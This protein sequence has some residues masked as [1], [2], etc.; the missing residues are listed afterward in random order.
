MNTKQ[1]FL[2]GAPTKLKTYWVCSE[3]GRRAHLTWDESHTIKVIV[4][5]AALSNISVAVRG[6][7]DQKNIVHLSKAEN[8]DGS[9]VAT[10]PDEWTR[11]CPVNGLKISL[12][13]L[14]SHPHPRYEQSVV[15]TFPTSQETTS[16]FPHLQ[17]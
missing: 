16:I 4:Q 1:P 3:S 7:L 15:E 9:A 14:A 5:S 10:R 13:C 17:G 11:F 8:R 6:M 12:F 2:G